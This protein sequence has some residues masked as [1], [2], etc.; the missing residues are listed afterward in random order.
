MFNDAGILR[1]NRFGVCAAVQA[2]WFQL[3][4]RSDERSVVQECGARSALAKLL[5]TMA[6]PLWMSAPD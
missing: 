4:D 3:K 5:D 6:G 1:G 2:S